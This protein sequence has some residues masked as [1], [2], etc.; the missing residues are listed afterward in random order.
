MKYLRLG[1]IA[2][3]IFL[4]ARVDSL[5]VRFEIPFAIALVA[6]VRTTLCLLLTAG[7]LHVLHEVVLPPIR[8]GTFRAFVSVHDMLV[9]E[10]DLAFG[11]V[12]ESAGRAP[13]DHLPALPNERI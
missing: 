5:H 1:R 3:S 6:A 8:F 4:Y 11:I 10:S 12:T 9:L 13:V 2:G 7:G